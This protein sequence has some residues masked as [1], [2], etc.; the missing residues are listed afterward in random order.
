MTE[1]TA[2]PKRY[3]QGNHSHVVTKTI[4]LNGWDGNEGS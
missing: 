3:G 1:S 4:G 2:L